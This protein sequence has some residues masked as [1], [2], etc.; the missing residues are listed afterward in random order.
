LL[1]VLVRLQLIWPGLFARHGGKLAYD[2]DLSTLAQLSEGYA[3]GSV[4]VPFIVAVITTVPV[5]DS[6]S[7]KLLLHSVIPARSAAAMHQDR[8]HVDAC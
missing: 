6:S 5:H 4:V 1:C 7:V 2:F 3:A 8:L